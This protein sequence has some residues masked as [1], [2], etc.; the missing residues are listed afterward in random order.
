MNVR[1]Y[2]IHVLL[3]NGKTSPMKTDFGVQ[4][5]NKNAP[6][7]FKKPI[8]TWENKGKIKR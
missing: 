5:K 1:A 6:S 7:V 2:L 3:R 8:N 4:L